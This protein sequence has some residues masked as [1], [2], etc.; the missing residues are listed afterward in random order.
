MV[1]TAVRSNYL[2]VR[3]HFMFVDTVHVLLWVEE[4]QFARVSVDQENVAILVNR[5]NQV[6]V[7]TFDF[8]GVFFERILSL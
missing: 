7:D 1:F 5:N 8:L 2:E 6:I 3:I 4:I